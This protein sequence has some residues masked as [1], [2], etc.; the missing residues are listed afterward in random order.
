MPSLMDEIVAGTVFNR[1]GWLYSAVAVHD[2]TPVHVIVGFTLGHISGLRGIKEPPMAIEHKAKALQLIN[3]RM[4]DPEQATSDGSIGAVI[5]IAAYEVLLQIKTANRSD[6]LSA[7]RLQPQRVCL[8]HE[9]HTS[10]GFC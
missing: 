10:D 6:N 7:D 8:A 3:A 5:H 4:E 1:I 9:R 2:P